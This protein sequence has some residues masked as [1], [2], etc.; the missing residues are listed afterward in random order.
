VNPV[1]PSAQGVATAVHSINLIWQYQSALECDWIRFLLHDL[2]VVEIFDYNFEI[3]SEDSIVV[4]SSRRNV[5]RV[6]IRR[7]AQT[8]RCILYHISD[9][10]FHGTYNDYLAFNLVFRNYWSSAFDLLGIKMLPLGYTAGSAARGP[11]LRATDRQYIWSFAGA[12]KSSRQD[13]LRALDGVEPCFVHVTDAAPALD[14]ERYLGVMRESIFCPCPM[15]NVNL[16][17]FRLYEALEAGCIPI[18]E[19]RP[20]MNYYQRIFTGFRPPTVRSWPEARTL[21]TRLLRDPADLDAE[22]QEI[23]DWW[24]NEKLR[25]RAEVTRLVTDCLFSGTEP[26]KLSHFI[27]PIARLPGWRHLELLRHQSPLVAVR[28]A[29]LDLNRLVHRNA[30]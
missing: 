12:V 15:G 4:F 20:T 17:T 9:E 18:V 21:I 2:S 3:L 23:A 19:R 16:E 27:K 11:T 25:W 6:Y 13:V 26:R 28:R 30:R 22:Q 5:P 24:H 7:A 14:R 8:K 1:R 29:R 10:S